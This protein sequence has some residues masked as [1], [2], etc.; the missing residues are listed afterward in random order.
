VIT[1]SLMAGFDGAA[2]DGL[3]RGRIAIP[4]ARRYAAAVSR[5]TPVALSIRLSDQPSRP[6]PSTCCCFSSLKTL[7]IP[8]V[9]PQPL[10]LVNVSTLSEMAGFQVISNG[11]FWVITEGA[12]SREAITTTTPHV[13][14]SD[15][16][17]SLN[18]LAIS[19]GHGPSASWPC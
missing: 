10:H 7:A 15:I 12:G 14:R 8:A 9:G 18:D 5:R 1:T 3:P 11:R 19:G 13:R 6:S 2:V 4:A 16:A 17:L